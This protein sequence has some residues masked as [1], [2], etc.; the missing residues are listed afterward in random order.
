MK[1]IAVHRRRGSKAWPMASVRLLVERLED[2][3][4][5]NAGT[6]DPTFGSGS[7]FVV[8]DFGRYS[9]VTNLVTLPDGHS[10]AAGTVI[11]NGNI[12][13]MVARYNSD[14][15]PDSSF[16]NGG[17]AIADF[18]TRDFCTGLALTPDGHILV[19]AYSNSYPGINQAVGLAEFNLDGSVNTSFGTNGKVL[20]PTDAGVI[21]RSLLVQPNGKIVVAGQTG[22]YTQFAV[23]QELTVY[24]Y[25]AVGSLD[26]SFGSGGV[27]EILPSQFGY[28]YVGFAGAVL[29]FGKVVIAGTLYG[30]DPSAPPSPGVFVRLTSG[31][32]VD[33]WH[34]VGDFGAGPIA[35]GP[36]Q[37]VVAV[38]GHDDF[39]SSIVRL[40]H[41]LTVDPTY[42]S[43]SITSQFVEY[44]LAVQNDGKV[45]AVGSDFFEEG[46]TMAYRTTRTG[47][48]DT[49]FGDGGMSVYDSSTFG[50]VMTP[51]AVAIQPDGNILAG[52]DWAYGVLGYWSLWRYTG[53]PDNPSASDKPGGA[54][55]A[56]SAAQ[57][58][59]AF[60]QLAVALAQITSDRS[61][62]HDPAN[63]DA[64]A[65]AASSGVRAADL[66]FA[67]TDFRWI[68]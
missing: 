45:V 5:L 44:A 18:Q 34:T 11:G 68:G 57:P 4:L 58:R 32:A 46:L 42:N 49:F 3:T 1:L 64:V 19:S 20:T 7:G 33:V 27:V 26:T 8:Q 21:F 22:D 30:D 51:L 55:T 24:R 65:G 61:L 63:T 16:G 66:L 59:E 62:P 56:A 41:D 23:A 67:A 9:Q 35:V 2:R 31:G 28:S 36:D 48:P 50:S 13:V 54:S 29:Q 53:R 17:T 52:G 25:T 47:A 39:S 14:G 12:D 43:G 15:S 40:K 38:I 37:R 10:L 60:A 6:L